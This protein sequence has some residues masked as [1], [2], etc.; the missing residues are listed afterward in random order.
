MN[1]LNTLNLIGAAMLSADPDQDLDNVYDA[2]VKWGL[3][4]GLTASSETGAPVVP[5]APDAKDRLKAFM[6]ASWSVIEKALYVRGHEFGYSSQFQQSLSAISNTMLV[7]HPR[8]QWDP[9]S[10]RILEPTDA[11]LEVIFAEKRQAVEEAGQLG[12]ILRPDTL[13]LPEP[14][15]GEL[16]AM[17][18]LFPLY[19]EGFE[20]SAHVYF[21]AQRALHTGQPEHIRIA[22]DNADTLDAFAARLAAHFESTVF[23]HYVYWL[24]SP[25]RLNQLAGECRRQLAVHEAA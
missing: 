6:R 2:W 3:Y 11:N 10:A 13:G 22:L 8:D 25:T 17:L 20:R 12:A 19:A 4:S 18:E 16:K 7:W 23:P 5:T 15:V 9:G 14:F 21:T 1:S 24:A